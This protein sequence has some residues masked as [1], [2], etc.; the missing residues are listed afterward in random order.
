MG[1]GRPYVRIACSGVGEQSMQVGMTWAL[2]GQEG[3]HILVSP[4]LVSAVGYH[5]KCSW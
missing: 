5:A 3:L 2:S 1:C 4:F